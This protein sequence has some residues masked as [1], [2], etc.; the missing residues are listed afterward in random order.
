MLNCL[1]RFSCS[2]DLSIIFCGIQLAIFGLLELY[3]GFLVLITSSYHNYGG[4]FYRI[5]LLFVSDNCF[6]LGWYCGFCCFAVSLLTYYQTKSY[7]SLFFL[8]IMSTAAAISSIL[9]VVLQVGELKQ[10]VSLKAC[11][12]Y[13]VTSH[14][15]CIYNHFGFDCYGDD[16]YFKEARDC[17]S[18]YEYAHETK[19][20]DCSCVLTHSTDD[21]YNFRDMKYCEHYLDK[22]PSIMIVSFTLACLCLVSS[23]FMVYFVMAAFR[24]FGSGGPSSSNSYSVVKTNNTFDDDDEEEQIELTSSHRSSSSS[25]S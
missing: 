12:S 1:P 22:M 18:K 15:T 6:A 13:S 23:C 3:F 5:Q 24:N 19:D 4:M 16:D 2:G 7:G 11:A 10:A 25:N 21:C 14:S 17:L 9:A 8:L 20:D